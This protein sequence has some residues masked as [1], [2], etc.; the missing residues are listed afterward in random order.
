M[1]RFHYEAIDPKGRRVP[2]ILE[3]DDEKRLARILEEKGQTLITCSARPFTEARASVRKLKTG[4]AGPGERSAFANQMARLMESA[5]P[6]DKALDMVASI[7]RTQAMDS[8][9]REA[10]GDVQQ[11]LSLTESLAKHPKVFHPLF[12]A[13]VRAGESGGFLAKAFAR[14]AEFELKQE[15]LR[16]KVVGSLMYPVF[17]ILTVLACL[18]VIMVF[19]VPTLTDFFAKSK[20]ELPLPTV[21][22]I[23]ISNNAVAIFGTLFGSIGAFTALYWRFAETPA[24]RERR[25]RLAL[26]LPVIG[27]LM[28]TLLL[29][30]FCRTM[31]L[32]LD[33]GVAVT[34][35]LS[36]TR[37]AVT[38]VVYQRELDSVCE[39][40]TAGE[41]MSRCL[42]V[43]RLFPELL[44]GQVRFGEETG[45]LPRALQSLAEEY[46]DQ[47][48]GAMDTLVGLLEPM[49]IVLMGSMMGSI[50]IAIFMPMANMVN[51]E[52]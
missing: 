9:L 33:G 12:L 1:T 26:S 41:A 40:V 25:D 2:G 27:S 21:I 36:I 42:E 38:N 52:K 7:V 47:A 45:T 16:R 18:A 11:G 50:V 3:C 14:L 48:S 15:R 5:C 28:Q 29:E 22:L 43:S 19:V 31:A 37:E 49:I 8:A 17:M 10:R 13:S 20:M 51:F 32:L 24:V 44:A 35:A 23:A 46:E 34:R 4:A 30:R 6:M 39:Q